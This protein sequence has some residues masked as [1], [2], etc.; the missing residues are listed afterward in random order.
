MEHFFIGEST[1]ALSAQFQHKS[2]KKKESRRKPGVSWSI[3]GLFNEHRVTVFR[4]SL[5]WIYSSSLPKMTQTVLLMKKWNFLQLQR[6][7]TCYFTSQRNPFCLQV[8]D[9]F[10]L[11]CAVSFSVNYFPINTSLVG[12]PVHLKLQPPHPQWD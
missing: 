9:T 4:A 2:G 7:G 11:P 12:T 10:L 3:L 8:T 5:R 1:S 6:P